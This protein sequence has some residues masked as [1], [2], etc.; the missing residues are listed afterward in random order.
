MPGPGGTATGP[1]AAWQQLFGAVPPFRLVEELTRDGWT[2]ATVAA[3]ADVV[4]TALRLGSGVA[5]AVHPPAHRTQRQ[6][7]AAVLARTA[8]TLVLMAPLPLD[9]AMGWLRVLATDPVWRP[10]DR[11]GGLVYAGPGERRP[12][13]VWVAGPG[14][15]AEGSAGP[16]GAGHGVPHAL[17]PLAHAAGLGPAE[18]ARLARAGALDADE[19]RTLAALRGHPLP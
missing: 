14:G 10:A 12:L 13:E 19:L 5:R 8:H 15:R 17:A 18:A 6:E 16:G 1:D 2:P 7:L 4:D 9:H 3:L 11:P